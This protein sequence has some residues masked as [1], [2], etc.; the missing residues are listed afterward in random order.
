MKLF[1][2]FGGEVGKVF[3][4]KGLAQSLDHGEYWIKVNCQLFKTFHNHVSLYQSVDHIIYLPTNTFH[5]S[6]MISGLCL[7]YQF[8]VSFCFLCLLVC[9]GIKEFQKIAIK[10]VRRLC[11]ASFIS[12]DKAD[13]IICDSDSFSGLWKIKFHMLGPVVALKT[14][15]T[16][17]ASWFIF[18][19]DLTLEV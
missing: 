16:W 8:F 5:Q 11:A 9:Q 13:E 2:F 17:V 4:G 14:L 19:L 18:G 7:K 15:C 3:A 10:N 12:R 1:A 6:S